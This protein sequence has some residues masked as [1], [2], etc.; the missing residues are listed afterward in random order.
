[1]SL[2]DDV[3]QDLEAVFFADFKVSAFINGSSV[4]GYFYRNSH[5]FG[6][7]G[8]NQV[9]FEVP[10]N[11]LPALERRQSIVIGNETYT[12][13]NREPRGEIT[14]LILEANNNG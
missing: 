11:S 13:I 8:A 1:M 3:N 9:R 7:I 12:Y 14:S 2:L 5:E 6:D 10:T 4:L